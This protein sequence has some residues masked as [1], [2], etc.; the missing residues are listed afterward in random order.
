MAA[1][2][3]EGAQN[4]CRRAGIPLAGG[5]SIDSKEPIFGLAVTGLVDIENI[6]SNNKALPGCEL[7]LTKPLGIGII[8]TAHKQKIVSDGD[9]TFAV[10]QMLTLNDVGTELAHLPG[11]RAM[12]DVTGYGLL[13]HLIE[14]CQGSYVSAE[15]DFE[16]VPVIPGIEQYIAEK[17]LPGGTHRNYDSYGHKVSRLSDLQKAILCDPQTSG[18]LLIVVDPDQKI[19]FIKVM[20]QKGLDIQPF[21]TIVEKKDVWVEIR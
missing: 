9:L 11:L 20:K 17:T 14:I 10:D 4:A 2:V 16:K 6:K 12:T 7:Y 5:H 15:I 1:R 13:G 18:G 19:E 21:G 3:V 8:T